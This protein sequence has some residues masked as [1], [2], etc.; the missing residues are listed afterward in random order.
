MAPSC[1]EKL[2]TF[3]P[4]FHPVRSF[5]LNSE[6]QPSCAPAGDIASNHRVI[7]NTR[8]IWPPPDASDTTPFYQVGMVPSALV[9]REC[10]ARLTDLGASLAKH[11]AHALMR[12]AF[13]LL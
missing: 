8:R 11:V 2:A 1:T 12:A 4:T 10:P 3:P 5:P 13:T 7:H 6:I 9:R